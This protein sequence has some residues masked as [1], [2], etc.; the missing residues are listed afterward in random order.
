MPAS[1]AQYTPV[2]PSDRSEN[3]SGGGEYDITLLNSK[4]FRSFIQI[5]IKHKKMQ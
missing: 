5:K 1:I 2:P 3:N 4:T